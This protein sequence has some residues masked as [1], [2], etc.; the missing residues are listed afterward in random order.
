M[1]LEIK[2]ILEFTVSELSIAI[3]NIIEDNFE[4]VKVRGEIGRVST[5]SSGHIYLD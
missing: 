2:N 3:K 4:Y 5:P 1:N